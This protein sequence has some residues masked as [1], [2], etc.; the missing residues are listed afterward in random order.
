MTTD[1]DSGVHYLEYFSK[2]FS[3]DIIDSCQKMSATEEQAMDNTK[4]ASETQK[5]GEKSAENVAAEEQQSTEA[6]AEQPR[7]DIHSVVQPSLVPTAFQYHSVCDREAGREAKRYCL[8]LYRSSTHPV[9]FFIRI[10]LVMHQLMEKVQQGR[11]VKNN[12]LWLKENHHKIW[13]V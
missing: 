5:T 2:P 1:R 8:G 11:K 4:E 13:Q 10:I 6:P 7:S 3:F 12:P 9:A